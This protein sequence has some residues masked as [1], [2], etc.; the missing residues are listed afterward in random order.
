VKEYYFHVDNTP[1][2]RTCACSTSTRRRR[3]DG[4]TTYLLTIVEHV[5]VAITIAARHYAAVSGY[6][7]IDLVR[8]LAGDHASPNFA[9]TGFSRPVVVHDRDRVYARSP[10]AAFE[11]WA[12][13]MG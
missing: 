13:G 9:P 11:R 8:G 10:S 4:K 1:T 6:D 2:T 3:P 12:F 7:L 5:A